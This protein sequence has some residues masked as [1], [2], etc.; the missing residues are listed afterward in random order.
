[1]AS[2]RHVAL[3]F[4]LTAACAAP[5]AAQE[6]PARI[7]NTTEDRK[8]PPKAPPEGDPLGLWDE[9]EAKTPS[10]TPAPGKKDGRDTDHI[11][12]RSPTPPA[13]GASTHPPAS[14]PTRVP[15]VSSSQPSG[16]P[17]T[18]APDAPS[19]ASPAPLPGAPS[20]APLA[21]LPDTPGPLTSAPPK[22]EE[23][24]WKSR[25]S[26]WTQLSVPERTSLELLSVDYRRFLGEALT[27]LL[28]TDEVLKRAQARGYHLWTPGRIPSPGERLIFVNRD[29]SI[30]LVRVGTAPLQDGVRIIGAHIDSPRIEL[31]GR[32]FYQAQELVL[33][34][35]TYHGGIKKYQWVNVPLALVGRITRLDGSVAQVRVGLEQDDPVLV[36]PDTAPHEDRELR[37]RKQTEVIKGEELDPLLASIPD[38]GSPLASL[39][40]RV[41]DRYRIQEEDLVGAE[42]QLV[43]ALPPREIGL[44]RSMIGAYGQ[45]DKAC[46]FA[47]V[48]ALLDADETP[49]KTAMVYL[50]DNEEVGSNNNTSADSFFLRDVLQQLAS[51]GRSGADAQGV[52]Y[53]TLRNSLAVSADANT[54]I[55]P[56]F[57]GTQEESN[58]SRLGFGV[59]V[60][61]YGQGNSAN[62]ETIALFRRLFAEQRI[63]WQTQTPR[64]DVGGG[65]TIGGFLSRQGIEVIDL[66]VPLLAMHAPFEVSSKADVYFM[67]QALRAFVSGAPGAPQLSAGAPV[68]PAPE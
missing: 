45:D 26:A 66:G 36:I 12:S 18:R 8:P 39:L 4:L 44:D 57:A 59:A 60:K 6:E 28:A 47:A 65:G 62:S 58:A 3:A 56:T 21:A 24:V 51:A 13:P 43:P 63:P 11:G 15:I 34:Q 32:P 22:L 1:M 64:V 41:R 52:L 54:G 49:A 55:N 48:R 7:W 19:T 31:K 40:A 38:G 33:A 61:L 68:T 37:E 67:Y 25:K 46:A 20:P 9:P 42:L 16:S 2:L 29:R 14:A 5:A 50:V 17:S 53:Q 30:L 23:S 27:E 10:P 35:T